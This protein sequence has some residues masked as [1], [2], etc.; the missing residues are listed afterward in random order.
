MHAFVEQRAAARL[1]KIDVPAVTKVRLQAVEV[2]VA[3]ARER[4]PTE[5]A[6]I[7]GRGPRLATAHDAVRGMRV[8]EAI[9]RSSAERGAAVLVAGEAR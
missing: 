5:L 4:E 2:A 3:N 1:C 7:T 8:I 9:A 6:G